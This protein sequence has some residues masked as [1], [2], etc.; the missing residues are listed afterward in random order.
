MKLPFIPPYT[1]KLWP[2]FE[3]DWLSIYQLKN[4]KGQDCGFEAHDEYGS[5]L[6][7]GWTYE[8]LEN[9]LKVAR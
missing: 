6:A 7:T 2:L 4:Y 3:S 9:R 5:T 1:V 8:Q